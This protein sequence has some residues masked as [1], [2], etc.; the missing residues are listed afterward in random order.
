MLYRIINNEIN[1]LKL[2]YEHTF[3]S[4]RIL[5]RDLWSS[6][7]DLN[8]MHDF[9]STLCM[10]SREMCLERSPLHSTVSVVFN[11]CVMVWP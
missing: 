9:K 6:I 3:S 11:Q 5:M 8:L 2:G 1:I 4:A 10:F 7:H